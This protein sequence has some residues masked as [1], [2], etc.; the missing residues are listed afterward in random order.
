MELKQIYPYRKY[1]PL[2]LLIV[3]NGIE[4]YV[5]LNGRPK[6]RILLIV[7]N[8]IETQEQGDGAAGKYAFNRTKWN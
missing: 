3:L 2:E 7:L 8:G 5:C 6:L 1:H 4:T